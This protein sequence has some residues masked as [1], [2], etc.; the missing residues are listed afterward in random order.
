[1]S[2]HSSEHHAEHHEA[3]KHAAHTAHAQHVDGAPA[4]EP[5]KVS[6]FMVT[7]PDWQTMLNVVG[8]CPAGLVH[9]LLTFMRAQQAAELNVG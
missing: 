7:P 4:A 5:K 3:H 2:E 9:D 6:A 1:M 8:M